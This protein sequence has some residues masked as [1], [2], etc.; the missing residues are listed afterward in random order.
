[1]RFVSYKKD[2]RASFGLVVGDGVVDLA[3]RMPGVSTL[4]QLLEGKG[5]AAAAPFANPLI[6]LFLGGFII[7][8]AMQRWH[9]HRRLA[10]NL[11]AAMGT[12]PRR[13][14][15]SAASARASRGM[16]PR[17]SSSEDTRRPLM[18]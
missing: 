1:M 17:N 15:T 11:I 13:I 7:A 2:G 6:F 16:A 14:Q 10:I 3:K 8:L 18:K 5:T 9:L 12:A 4:R